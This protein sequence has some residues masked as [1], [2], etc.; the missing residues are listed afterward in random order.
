MTSRLRDVRVSRHGAVPA[1]PSRFSVPGRAVTLFPCQTGICFQPK[2]K[3]HE[4][5][6]P[7]ADGSSP[8]AELSPE[9]A[10]W[11]LGLARA[12]LTSCANRLE[13]A[14]K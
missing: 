10:P 6:M 5:P 14:N 9:W 11:L 8:S 1:L 4:A 2:L 3:N 12:W 13:K 7:D